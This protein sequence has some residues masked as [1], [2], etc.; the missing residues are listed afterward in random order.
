MTITRI[1]RLRN[2]GVFRDFTWP[3]DLPEFA[4]FNLIYGWNWSGKTTLSKMVMGA[5]SQAPEFHIAGRLKGKLFDQAQATATMC[6]R[7]LGVLD[8]PV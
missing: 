7:M 6:T 1:G 3:S 4:Q 8:A 2:Y 5:I